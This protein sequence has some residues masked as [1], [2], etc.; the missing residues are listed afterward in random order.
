MVLIVTGAVFIGGGTDMDKS[1][2]DARK[3]F[4]QVEQ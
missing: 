4:L 3:K 1:R 2:H